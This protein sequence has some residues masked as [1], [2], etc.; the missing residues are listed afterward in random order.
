MNDRLFD[1]ALVGSRLEDAQSFIEELLRSSTEVSI[2]GTGLDGRILL[3]NEG[4]RRIY[5]YGTEEVLGRA[6]SDLLHAEEDAAAGKGEEMRQAALRT[7]RWEGTVARRRKNGAR[8]VARV[9]MTPRLDGAG[10]PKGFLLISRDVSEEF[11][12][13]R[14]EEKFRGLLESAPD[15][16]V[17]VDR[18]GRIVLVNA[19]AESL[20]GYGRQELLG[21]PVELLVPD[22]FRAR[23]PGHRTDFFEQPR[24]RPM[25]AGRELFGRRKDG[26][27]FPVE[28]SL[29]PL[30]TPEG[31]LVSSAIRDLTE[32]KRAEEKFRSLLESAPDAMVIVDRG[33]RIVL[34]NAQTESLFGYARA[35]LLGQPVEML[36]PER[37]RGA[38]PGHRTSFFAQP[39]V[40]PMGAGKELFGRRKDGTEFPVEISLSPLQTAEGTLVSG[41][42]R[43]ITDRRR[44]EELIRTSLTE[45]EVLL[46]EIHHRVKNNLQI[47]T[48]LLSLQ[49]DTLRDAG[50]KAALRESQNRVRAMALIHETLYG[51][52]D[53]ARLDFGRYVREL[54]SHLQ[55]SYAARSPVATRVT[56]TT[57][58]LSIET[59][60]PCGLV[61]NELVSNALKYAFPDEGKGTI[62]VSMTPADGAGCLL[63][64]ADDGRG[65][66]DDFE[67]RAASSLG[68]RLVKNLVTQL[69]GSMR[70]DGAEPGTRFTISFQDRPHG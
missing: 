29:S 13:A 2:V 57:P 27:E 58:P 19:Q 7:G 26:T 42:I 66:P 65:L 44:A 16:M 53:L 50:A 36:V 54:V 18:D 68:F 47:I 34:V 5:G 41:A 22:R 32:R 14:A 12:A 70:R 3:W 15:A 6:S 62:T 45:K 25:G 61:I 28:I 59:A 1:P 11:R 21:Q 9:S 56:V 55:R 48:S 33:G 30:Q 49:G 67:K 69:G 52:L 17:I 23:H 46:K 40:R 38:H 64:V 43:D 8:F 24:L 51:G 63:E 10:K 31:T 39:R 37:F 60:I 4:A 35:E 20:F